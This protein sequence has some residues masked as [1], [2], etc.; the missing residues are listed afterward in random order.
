[1]LEFKQYPLYHKLF[2]P[3]FNEERQGSHAM[4]KSVPRNLHCSTA[5]QATAAASAPPSCFGT[6]LLHGVSPSPVEKAKTKLGMINRG[7][8]NL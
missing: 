8:Q 3:Q 4:I 2:D 1:M 6:C 7:C 5:N